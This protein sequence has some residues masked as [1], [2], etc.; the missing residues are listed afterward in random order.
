MFWVNFCLVVFVQSES[1]KSCVKIGKSMSVVKCPLCSLLSLCAA[2]GLWL[3]FG[4]FIFCKGRVKELI[5]FAPPSKKY[6]LVK[7]SM[8]VYCNRIFQ[9]KVLTPQSLCVSQHIVTGDSGC[10][11]D[12]RGRVT[13][14]SYTECKGR[15]ECLHIWCKALYFLCNGSHNWQCPGW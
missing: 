6:G 5:L 13:S 11:L 9:N 8:I 2:Y 1:V 4:D 12:G 3:H 14:V 15:S 10:V 7:Q